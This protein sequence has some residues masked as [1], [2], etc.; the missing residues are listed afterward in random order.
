MIVIL[1]S[2]KF[3]ILKKKS[4]CLKNRK[5]FIEV[6]DFVF[7]KEKDLLDNKIIHQTKIF[8]KFTQGKKMCVWYEW[9][10]LQAINK[11][12]VF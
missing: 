9:F 3:E 8:E 2:K 10:M 5:W 4:Q 7:L 11:L 12:K 6:K 1:I